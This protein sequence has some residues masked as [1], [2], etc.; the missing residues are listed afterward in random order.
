MMGERRV[1]E[2]WVPVAVLSGAFALAALTL[3]QQDF[4]ID[5]FYALY[6]I[7]RPF[8]EAV[9]TIIQP[10]H[11]GPLFFLLLWGWRQLVG[12]SAYAL[13]YLSLLWTIL[14]LAGTWRLAR[15]LAP[16]RVAHAAVLLLACAPLTLYYAQE[17]K[18][19]AL[20]MALGV[21]SSLALK[22][23]LV[24]NRWPDWLRYV[25][26][27]NLLGYSHF[28]GVFTIAAQG[29]L[30]LLTS[31]QRPRVRRAYLVTMA[32]AVLPYVPVAFFLLREFRGMAVPTG[33]QKFLPLPQLVSELLTIYGLRLGIGHLAFGTYLPVA[34]GLLLL[35]GL[36]LAW[37][38]RPQAALWIAALLGLPLLLYYPLS[39]RLPLFTARYFI[40]GM[41]FFAMALAWWLTARPR[42]VGG[43]VL[44]LLLVLDAWAVLRDLTNPLVQRPQ[45]RKLAAYLEAHGTPQDVIV[46]HNW[47][48]VPL[49]AH[50]Y[51]GPLPIRPF[52]CAPETCSAYAPEPFF[53]ALADEGYRAVWLVLYQDQAL[54]PG[55]EMTERL[56][57]HWPT[58]V[59][60]TD[61][62]GDLK[63]AA[64]VLNPRYPALPESA[65]ALAVPCGEGWTAR[66]VALPVRDVSRN[67]GFP[68]ATRLSLVIYWQ[69]NA[70]TA[71]V[72]HPEVVL[73]GE[74]GRIWAQALPVPPTTFALT[75]TTPTELLSWPVQLAFAPGF[76]AGRY[77]LEL[78]CDAGPVP[79]LQ[80]ELEVKP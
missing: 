75:P 28:F 56:A 51:H 18:M 43:L 77:T 52:E 54:T 34:F 11:N 55:H 63:V 66:G 10:Q 13:R 5:E 19:Y 74:D 25:L 20:F 7:D 12:T 58:L 36:G 44:S 60:W 49:L 30:A 37:R 59:P 14:A 8:L 6:Y 64:F 3:G 40:A 61:V 67:A 23:A 27:F 4:W 73:R 53:T 57:R 29:M 2:S 79:L 35:G 69:K 78:V 42:R 41:P 62:Y 48:A 22:R 47:F 46:V 9:R 32:L 38:Q 50:Y 21:L 68:L 17:A 72:P 71:M 16:A 45:W 70:A 76:P 15:D 80:F 26:A 1:A 24:R 31:W 65:Q 39:F 33:L